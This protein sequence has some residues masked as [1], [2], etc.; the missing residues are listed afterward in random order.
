MADVELKPVYLITGS[1]RPKVATALTRLRR[2]FAPE[3]LERVSAVEASAADAVALRPRIGEGIR[4]RVRRR[5]HERL[6]L[7]LSDRLAGRPRGHLVDLARQR[8]EILADQVHER[9]AGI[10]LGLDAVLR[11]A[12]PHPLRKGL[13]CQRVLEHVTDAPTRLPQRTRFLHLVADERQHGR[14]SRCAEVG[15]DHRDLCRLPPARQ[16]PLAAG[17]PV[18]VVDDHESSVSEQAARVAERDSIGPAR[19]QRGDSLDRLRSEVT[20]QARERRRDLRSIVPRD[21]VDGLEVDLSHRASLSS[22]GV[23]VAFSRAPW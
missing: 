12:L 21:Q 1:D 9:G 23:P 14:R 19:L 13:L 11:E 22:G 16:A 5:R 15:V 8:V 10:G 4:R 18:D 20:A 7:P 3:S 2:H 6:D 17:T